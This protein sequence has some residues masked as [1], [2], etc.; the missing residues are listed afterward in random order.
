MHRLARAHATAPVAVTVRHEEKTLHRAATRLAQLEV[1][2]QRTWWAVVVVVGNIEQINS[3]S[4]RSL[5]GNVLT[6]T[7]PVIDCRD[8]LGQMQ[9]NL[10]K[11]EEE[12][13]NNNNKKRLNN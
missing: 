9:K 2:G 8:W 5:D 11:V 13:V 6:Q 4:T 12:E 3:T 10:R 1:A 7:A